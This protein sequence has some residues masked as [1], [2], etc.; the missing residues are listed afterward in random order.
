MISKKQISQ[1]IEHSSNFP[2]RKDIRQECRLYHLLF[3][4]ALEEP[5]NK[6]QNGKHGIKIQ[7]EE[8]NMKCY[9]D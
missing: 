2:I 5:A 4:I 6:M 9:A 1:Q 3:V 7:I 8:Y